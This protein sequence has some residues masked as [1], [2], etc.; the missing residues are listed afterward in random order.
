MYE[1]RNINK[2]EM[3]RRVKVSSQLMQTDDTLVDFFVMSN[4]CI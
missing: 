2:G 4:I 1:A 3:S